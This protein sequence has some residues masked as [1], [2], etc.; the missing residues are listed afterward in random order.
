MSDH[1]RQTDQV[2]ASG[3]AAKARSGIEHLSKLLREARRQEAPQSSPE[4]GAVAEGQG[5]EQAERTEHG[6]ASD[7]GGTSEQAEATADLREAK[8]Q[9]V[10]EH[11][12]EP[13]RK[14][15]IN[16][17][18]AALIGL[19]L[20][21]N[22]ASSEAA[23]LEARQA[24]EV[25]QPEHV[26][27]VEPERYELNRKPPEINKPAEVDP[28]IDT[29]DGAHQLEQQRRIEEDAAGRAGE[30][31]TSAAGAPPDPGPDQEVG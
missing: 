19:P 7:E 15:H 24:A 5:G 25:P 22:I 8:A 4:E 17:V 9:K 10:P 14:R 1:K 11:R 28:E 18:E 2:R 30:P 29:L 31:T 6:P 20:L 12:P 21:F 13:E 23:T 26:L 3:D 16:K 27:V